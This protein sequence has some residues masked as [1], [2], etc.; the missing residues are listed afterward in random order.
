VLS[1]LLLY[2]VGVWLSEKRK[3]AVPTPA[4]SLV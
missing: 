4:R 3:Q 1:I 2:R